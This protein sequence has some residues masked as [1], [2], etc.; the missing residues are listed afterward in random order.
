M[1]IGIYRGKHGVKTNY[2]KLTKCKT[3]NRTTGAEKYM[4]NEQQKLNDCS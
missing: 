3:S 4:Q 2:V 1:F